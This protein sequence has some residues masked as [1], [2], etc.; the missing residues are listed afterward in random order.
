[1]FSTKNAL[2]TEPTCS[3]HASLMN[4][5]GVTVR[6]F[7]FWVTSYCATVGRRP[8][9]RS[10]DNSAC[11]IP[12]WMDADAHN[13]RSSEG[14]RYHSWHLLDDTTAKEFSSSQTTTYPDRETRFPSHY[15]WR[16]FFP[17]AWRAP[18]SE[19][20]NAP[21]KRKMAKTPVQRKD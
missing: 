8:G 19:P 11:F 4:V 6:S 15:P 5:P 14:L 12:L 20:R 3:P 2:R 16:S 10:L 9:K 13:S 17:G 21:P 1:M 18:S 7:A